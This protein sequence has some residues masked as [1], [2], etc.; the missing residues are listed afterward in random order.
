MI[1]DTEISIEHLE[2]I[3][4]FLDAN[5]LDGIT[6]TEHILEIRGVKHNV[7]RLI[8]VKEESSIALTFMGVIHA[9]VLNMFDD[10]L[11]KCGVYPDQIKPKTMYR[12]VQEEREAVVNKQ[13]ID[14]LQNKVFKKV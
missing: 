4:I 1:V 14:H 13:F 10:Y 6:A 8:S 9:G 3:K 11:L 12:Q 7:I 2:L 5:K